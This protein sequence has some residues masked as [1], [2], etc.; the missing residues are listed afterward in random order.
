[1]PSIVLKGLINAIIYLNPGTEVAGGVT[2]EVSHP[3]SFVHEIYFKLK[4]LNL[5]GV[6]LSKLST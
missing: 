1:M 2:E 3:A 5:F 4:Y 6:K